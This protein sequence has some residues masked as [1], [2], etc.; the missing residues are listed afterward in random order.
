[1]KQDTNTYQSRDLYFSAFLLASGHNLQDLIFDKSGGFFWFIFQ[2]KEQCENL[3]ALFQLNKVVV[4][5]K[6]MAESIK[7]LKK[8]VTQ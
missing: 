5:A 4:N 7:Y 1:M 6:D 8:R 2:N 3:D